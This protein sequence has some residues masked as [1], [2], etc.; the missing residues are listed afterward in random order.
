M[1]MQQDVSHDNTFVFI[2]HYPALVKILFPL[3]FIIFN[4]LSSVD[5]KIL[6]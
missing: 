6:Q 2:C 3:F 5:T 4:Q 1:F